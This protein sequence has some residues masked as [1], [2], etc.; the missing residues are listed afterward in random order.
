MQGLDSP[1]MWEDL[2]VELD[3]V[4]VG[5]ARCGTTWLAACL[6]EHPS[7]QLPDRKELHY[8]NSER[9]YEPR[10]GWLAERFDAP[11]A[12]RLRGEFTPRYLL[13]ERALDRIAGHFPRARILVLLRDPVDRAWSQY[14]YFR[15][16]KKKE[17]ERDFER[18]LEGRYREDYVAKGRYGTALT[19]LFERFPRERVWVGRYETIRDD[20]AALLRSLF[21]FLEIDPD[22]RPSLLDRVVN[23]SRGG[24]C[25]PPAGWAT[26]VRWLTTTANPL[27]DRYRG[28]ILR[29][30]E[31][32]NRRLDARRPAAELERPDAATRERIFERYF[33][34]ELA[35]AEALLGEE[36]TAWRAS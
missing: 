29:R 4:G 15:L 35:R 24:H 36:L 9:K 12:G 23:A 18:A 27:V 6:A 20:P 32:V 10:L 1:A 25:L 31:R 34:A 8:F 5:A 28:R 16:V 17:P 30:V 26:T 13:S 7:V 22:F 2:P 11:A 19:R 14:S 33:A 3:F 21:A